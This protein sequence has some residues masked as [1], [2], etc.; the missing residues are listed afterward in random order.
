MTE[1]LDTIEDTG[2]RRCELL[3]LCDKWGGDFFVMSVVKER[4]CSVVGGGVSG[5]VSRT[6][7]R[8]ESVWKCCLRRDGGVLANKGGV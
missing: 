5:E 3:R 2:S 6:T 8:V 7:E 1:L 4:S